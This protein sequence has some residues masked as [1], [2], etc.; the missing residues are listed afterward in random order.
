MSTAPA[1]SRPYQHA[2]RARPARGG[3]LHVDGVASGAVFGDTP[4]MRVALLPS[5]SR[6]VVAGALVVAGLGT[7][8]PAE[9]EGEGEGEGEDVCAPRTLAATPSVANTG[10]LIA[11]TGEG[12]AGYVDGA[13]NAV[14]TNGVGGI[15]RLKDGGFVFSDIFNGT[16]RI[17][18][19]AGAVRTLLGE[20]L[21]VGA[22]DGTCGDVRMNGP[23]GMVLD[24]DG[25][26]LWFGDG[27][28]LRKANLTTG[29]VDTFAGDC[30]SGGDVDGG[31]GIARFGF[32]F[33][34][35]EFDARDRELF[36]ADRANDK[37]RGVQ[38]DDGII[39][40]LVEGL[41]GPGGMAFDAATR[42]LYVANTFDNQIL[43]VDVDTAETFVVAGTGEAGNVDGDVSEATLDSPQALALVG[44]DLF[45]GGFDGDMRALNLSDNTV[46]TLERATLGVFASFSDVDDDGAVL[47]AD[48]DGGVHVL[49]QDGDRFFFGADAPAGY[50]DGNA[51]DARFALPASIVA[52]DDDTVWVTDSINHAIR[53]VNLT[54]GSTT[55]FVGGNEG[56]VDGAFDV[57]R[58]DFPAGLAKNAAGTALFVADNGADK[59]KKIDL[60]AETVTTLAEVLDPWEVALSADEQTLFVVSSELGELY[61]VN[62]ADNT[63][64]LVADGFTFPLGVAVVGG[65]VFVTDNTRHVL[66][67]VD[68]ATGEKAVVLGTFDFQG[69]LAGAQNVAALS[70]PSSLFA[71]VEDGADVLY[72]GETGGQVVRRIDLRDFSSTFVVGNPQL[73]GSLPQGVRVELAGAPILNPQDVVVVGGKIVIAGDTTVMVAI[74]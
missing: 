59:V 49:D 2:R 72:I 35:L 29:V 34:D 16:L 19:A 60:V 33:H 74:P 43:G 1:T 30:I 26:T 46:R 68:V 62:L 7:G 38:V 25:E 45:F 53:E 13:G 3:R 61:A 27:P 15:A 28:C 41:N 52:K 44:D 18:D 42:T 12:G 69:P 65:D 57:A 32:L 47:Y 17:V 36:I 70:F 37:V 71:T 54:T 6:F 9:G 66:Y 73:S 8:C 31:V 39:T 48:L 55:T 58:L 22:V 50:V 51:G 14:R 5:L 40:T 4:A 24:P 64:A 23:R 10:V 56:D 21:K 11:L 67:D 63:R 20:P